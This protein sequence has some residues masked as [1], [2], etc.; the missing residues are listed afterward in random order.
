MANPTF[1]TYG[2]VG[3][4][5]DL[6]DI[7]YNIAPTDTPFMSNVGKGSASGTYHEW[8]TDDL[9]AAADNKVAEA[10][11]A[12]AAESVA[13]TRVGN[14]TQIASKTVAYRVLTKPLMPQ[15]VLV[16]WHISWLR[17]V[18]N[19]SVTWRRL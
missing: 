4:R 2:T 10:A 7:I 14:Y 3:I 1:E 15:V 8:Q 6:A 11:A 9:T 13:T 16:K 19:S 12:P 17:K 18:W 5:E